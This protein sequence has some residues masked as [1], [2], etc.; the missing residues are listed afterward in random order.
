MKSEIINLISD[1]LE[2]SANENSTKENTENWDS[3]NHVY[4]VLELQDRFK[5]RIPAEDIDKLL[6]V[7]DIIEYI[8]KKTVND[9]II[10]FKE[11]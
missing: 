4:I 7:M 2:I 11:S 8:K 1:V 9:K 3:L 6:S 5:V 10:R